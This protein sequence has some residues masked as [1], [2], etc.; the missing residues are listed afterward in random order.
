[1]GTIWKASMAERPTPA[2]LY[3]IQFKMNCG[4]LEKIGGGDHFK[5][6]ALYLGESSDEPFCCNVPQ[7]PA[8]KLGT[9]PYGREK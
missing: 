2:P 9:R 7:S 6:G 5:L 8:V 1:M 3:A 4:C